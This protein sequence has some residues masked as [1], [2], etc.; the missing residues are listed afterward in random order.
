LRRL[1]IGLLLA[2]SL[3][4]TTGAGALAATPLTVTITNLNVQAGD[5]FLPAG[6]SV[7]PAGYT[8]LTIS[9]D[10]SQWQQTDDIFVFASYSTDGGATWSDQGGM[11]VNGGSH[12]CRGSTTQF[13]NATFS[14]GVPSGNGVKV[15]AHYV[16][17]STQQVSGSLTLN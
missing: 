12:F 16:V 9:L 5:N 2:L 10:L 11:E 17:P 15:R 6:G 14:A 7:I 4:A 8:Q 13:C 3:V 1:L